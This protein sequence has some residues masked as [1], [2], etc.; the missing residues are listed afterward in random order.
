MGLSVTMLQFQYSL[1]LSFSSTLAGVYLLYIVVII[2]III[3]I[4]I[5]VSFFF[6]YLFLFYSFLFLFLFYFFFFFI[7]GVSNYV[8]YLTQIMSLGYTTLQHLLWLQYTVHVMLFHTLNILYLYNRIL[9]STC[10]VPNVAL[11]CSSLISCSSGMIL[12]WF[13]LPL[14]LLA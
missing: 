5:I 4:I 1:K 7:Q 13:H 9:R 6:F 8:V 11:V 10:A 2:I 14:L 3:I 12:R